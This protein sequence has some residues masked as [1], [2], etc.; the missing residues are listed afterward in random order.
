MAAFRRFGF[1][2]VDGS[3]GSFGFFRSIG[4]LMIFDF[5]E[6]NGSIVRSGFFLFIM[7]LVLD[8]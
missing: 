8:G 6:H 2:D 7:G 1:F 4:L 5:L 3:L